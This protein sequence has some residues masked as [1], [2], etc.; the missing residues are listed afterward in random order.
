MRGVS[1]GREGGEGL[2][3]RAFNTVHASVRL[4]H[5]DSEWELRAVG[6]VDFTRRPMTQRA[7]SLAW[8]LWPWSCWMGGTRCAA[9]QG[10]H[11]DRSFHAKAGPLGKS[12]GAW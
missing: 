7:C 10:H 8:M 11:H 6:F 3:M 1:I 9:H 2:V 5:K 4:H 12:W